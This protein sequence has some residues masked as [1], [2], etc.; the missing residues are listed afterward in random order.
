MI[1]EQKVTAT[2]R[3]CG[4]LAHGDRVLVA[5]SGGSDSVALLHIL[6]E[7]GGEFGLELEVAHLQH[8]MRGEEARDDARF[9][10]KFAE[11]LKVPFHL[12]EIKLPQM[13]AD[14]G[15]GNIEA[16]GRAERYRFFADVARERKIQKI[17]TAH[18]LDDQAETVAMWFFRGAGLKGLG[19]MSPL[20]Q[21]VT[22]EDSVTVIRPLLEVSKAE[23]LQ[24]LE[25]RDLDYR[26]DRTNQDSALLRNWLRLDLL[27]R[28]QQRFGR[29]VP[30]R[31]AQQAE[32]FRHEDAFLDDLARSSYRA[33]LRA[34]CL[35]RPALLNTVKAVQR[36][37]LRLWIAQTRGHLRGLEF[38]HIEDMLRLIE[39]G[40]SQASVSIPGGWEMVRQYETLKLERRTR[41]RRGVCYDYPLEAGTI[42][43]IPEAGLELLSDRTSPPPKELPAD[44]M[45]AVF[46]LDCVRGALSVRNFR[47]GDRFQPLGMTGH[48]KIKDLFIEKRL[49]ISIRANWPLLVLGQEVLWIPGYGRS[50]A[51]CVST[52]TTAV[53]HLKAG[54]IPG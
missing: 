44:L 53:L 46:D 52:K 17:A 26:F 20:H 13:K 29:R 47:H 43:R 22:N 38:I 18:T 37:I 2:I 15:K 4:L 28:I 33:M 24:Y 14:A 35:S 12:K 41:S 42:L 30:V 9:A 23:I 27:P 10:A 5:L 19:G 8:G 3:R 45:E 54:P 21:I 7:L 6:R 34:G 11:M 40:P 32:I 25:E 36:R 50:A 1:I 48:K 51:A 16:L 39:R 49:P 31:L